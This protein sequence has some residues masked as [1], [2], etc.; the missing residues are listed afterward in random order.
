[1]TAWRFAA[2]R[3]TAWR[4]AER[5]MTAC[6]FAGEASGRCALITCHPARSRR[7]HLGIGPGPLARCET[8]RGAGIL[9]RAIRDIVTDMRIQLASDLHLELLAHTWPQER[10]V[11]AAPGAD[12]LV[13]AGDIDRGLRA[14]ERFARWP[15]PVLYV[16]GNHEF[17]D[18]DW[19]QLRADLRRVAAGT[20]VRFLDN[21]AVTLGGVRFLGSTLWTDYLSAGV[22]QSEAMRAAEDL[23]LDHRRIR[24][25]TGLFSAAQALADHRRSRAWL[26]R[27]LSPARAAPTVVITHHGPHP[28]SIHPRFAGSPVNGGFVSD[29]AELVAQADLWL[30]GHVHDSFDYRVG[31]CRVVTN[32]RGY[33][34]NR[35]D[36]ASVDELRFEN[37]A[38]TG[39]RLL[40][41]PVA[42]SSD[43]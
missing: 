42:P 9:A 29:L 39:D 26:A 31:R 18:Q 20:A 22:P 43:A 37:P 23:L 24:T 17:Y 38:F 28:A 2:R 30:H 16:A 1:M 21:D 10:L 13:L 41:V 33:A 8:R 35:K 3:M 34:Q 15:V 27:E 7:I 6:R 25:R 40:E 14:I 19:E 5:R 4:F 11:A 36:V 32:P 12:V